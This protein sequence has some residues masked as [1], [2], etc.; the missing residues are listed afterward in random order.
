MTLEQVAKKSVI[1]IVDD[2]EDT[3]CV[4]SSY[5][6]KEG[7]HIHA[8]SNPKIALEHFRYSPSECSLIISDVRM[9]QISGFQLA[10]KVKEINP[11]VK[12]ILTS[13]LEVNMPEFERKAPNAPVDAFVDKPTGLKKLAE[14]VKQHLQAT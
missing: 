4:F 9:P 5:L 11:N 8:F 2:D 12:I 1:M 14:V 13:S 3:L 7:Y 6:I 10:R